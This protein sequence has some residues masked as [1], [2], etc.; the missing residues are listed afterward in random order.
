MCTV[1]YATFID[2]LPSG[3]QYFPV[4]KEMGNT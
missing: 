2:P 3:Y 1:K 4:E